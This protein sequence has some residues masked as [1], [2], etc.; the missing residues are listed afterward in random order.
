M[1]RKIG[2][3]ASK[4]MKAVQGRVRWQSSASFAQQY[5][6]KW[7]KRF[8]QARALGQY[9]QKMEL[10]DWARLFCR[11]E[12]ID[13]HARRWAIFRLAGETDE[14]LKARV[15]DR[16]S[17]KPCAGSE[18]ALREKIQ[19]ALMEKF[20]GVKLS[21]ETIARIQGEMIDVI[22]AAVKVHAPVTFPMPDI[23]V[24]YDKE[25]NSM[26]V[27]IIPA[28]GPITIDFKV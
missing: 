18:E 25:A 23:S 17:D 14:Q 8:K 22:S 4:V 26:D 6:P 2:K 1:G 12:S 3:K 15:L 21:P 24:K 5:G 13:D 19:V 27:V 10:R 7:H 20:R 28:P 16:I 11:P 9:S